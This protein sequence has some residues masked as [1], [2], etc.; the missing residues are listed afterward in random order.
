MKDTYRH[1]GLRKQLIQSL[2]EK[3][4][5]DERIL[6]AMMQLPR[7]FFLDK[8]FEERAYE[9]KAFPI[10]S[11][12]TIS[13][14]YTVAYQTQLLQVEKHQKVLEIGTGSGYQAAVLKLLGA[15]VFSV[16]RQ[17]TLFLETQER[18]DKLGF[19]AIKL[20]LRDGYVGLKEFAPFD[21]ILV[22]AG[23]TEIPKA[24][25]DQ[26]AIDGK[27]VIPVGPEKNKV[28]MR[29]T[30]AAANKFL[31]ETFDL[32]RFVPFLKGINNKSRD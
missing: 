13:Q 23:A 5:E 21:R 29:I 11:S 10:G 18:L 17:E 14:P 22:T 32:F 15:R 31:R 28:M 6:N 4:I 3:G 20:F 16:E 12:Q 26:L 24:L 1:Q 25:L 27:L 2:S 30:K 8:A 7:H 19:Q 9:D